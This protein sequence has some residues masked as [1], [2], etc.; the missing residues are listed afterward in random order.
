MQVI[1]RRWTLEDL[2]SLVKYG[3]NPGIAANLT[4]Q[5]PHPYTREK[6]EAFIGY[7]TGNGT[8]EIF[9]ID[10]DGEACG[11]IG[12]HPQEDIMRQNA[13]L[14]YWLAEPFWGRGVVTKAVKLIVDYGFQNLDI[15]RIYAR[16]FGENIGSQ[17]VLEKAGFKFETKFDKTIIKNGR[18]QDE[19]FYAIRRE[20]WEQ[21]RL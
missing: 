21:K 8:S 7:A 11:A 10:I 1:I 17:R 15:N 18:L 6:G 3:N 2:D 4:D 14:G 16:P 5:F 9:A 20:E 13:E 12:L 19:L